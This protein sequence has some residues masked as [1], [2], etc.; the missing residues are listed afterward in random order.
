MAQHNLLGKKGE[1]LAVDF[2]LKRDY[3]I[4]ERNFI[5]QIKITKVILYEAKLIGIIFYTI[6]SYFIRLYDTRNLLLWAGTIEGEITYYH[7]SEKVFC[8]Y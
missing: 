6:K 5:S 7:W 3:E 8:Y 2:L 4:I 1:Q